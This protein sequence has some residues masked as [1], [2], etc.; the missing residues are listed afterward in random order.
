MKNL[1]GLMVMLGLVSTTVAQVNSSEQAAT[2]WFSRPANSTSPGEISTVYKVDGLTRPLGK[3]APGEFFGYPVP[4]GTH[5]F[6]YT[7][8]P[9]RGQSLTLELKSG[10]QIFV[11]VQFRDFKRVS[12]SEGIE[13][14]RK[15]QPVPEARV[16]DRIVLRKFEPVSLASITPARI[17]T[18]AP[19]AKPI[20]L[21]PPGAPLTFVPLPSNTAGRPPIVA[22]PATRTA[23]AAVSAP[24]ASAVPMNS[25]SSTGDAAAL[26][27][28]ISMTPGPVSLGSPFVAPVV[29]V[30][31]AS[32][33]STPSFSVASVSRPASAPAVANTKSGA[34][35]A[36]AP[37]PV[38]PIADPA[39]R[40][41]SSVPSPV[42]V[43]ATSV[44]ATTAQ[45][46]V[47]SRTEPPPVAPVNQPTPAWPEQPASFS[48]VFQKATLQAVEKKQYVGA[49]VAFDRNYFWILDGRG[50]T[51]K[52]FAYGDIKIAEY[53]YSRSAQWNTI[54]AGA[55]ASSTAGG[56]R[57]WFMVQTHDDYVLLQLD[58]ENY[59]SVVRA[60]ELR[61]GKKIETGE[62]N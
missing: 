43:P 8:A 4:A 35:P 59:R 31:A 30:A 57:H 41:A 60:F 61:T 58:K 6:S 14:I 26:K 16:L 21:P 28:G 38:T 5:V 9:A 42:S 40:P 25:T 47:A 37:T 34:Q 20:T 62:N 10:E 15:I 48:E 7:R 27:L 55:P 32:K 50:K 11:E 24:V 44:Q 3:I 46:L 39:S 19:V 36:A 56:N 33:P 13:A 2:V 23:P 49:L 45:P 29:S 51:V 22:T 12:A 54:A 53:A 52:A 18:S 1:F 17:T